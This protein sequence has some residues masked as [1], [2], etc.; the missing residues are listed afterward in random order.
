MSTY[1]TAEEL[2]AICGRAAAHKLLAAYGGTSVFIPGTLTD[3]HHPLVA[4]MGATAADA[5]VAGICTGHGG[6]QISLPLGPYGVRARQR[7]LLRAA[8]IVGGSA[9]TIARRLGVS[10]RTVRRER[11]RQLR[12]NMA[13]GKPE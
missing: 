10:I 1:V 5:L 8:V 12:E 3:D 13:E 4:I 9:T 11:L 7:E 2:E 6:M